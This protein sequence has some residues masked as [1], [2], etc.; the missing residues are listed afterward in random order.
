MSNYFW[1]SV[2][3]RLR[4][5]LRDVY[6]RRR[7]LA[8]APKARHPRPHLNPGAGRSVQRHVSEPTYEQDFLNECDFANAGECRG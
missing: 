7:H 1:Q 4:G 3:C 2:N 6:P 8:T 5:V